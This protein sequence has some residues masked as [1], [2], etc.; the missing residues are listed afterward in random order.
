MTSDARAVACGARDALQNDNVRRAMEPAIS[1]HAA[2]SSMGSEANPEVAERVTLVCMPWASTVRPSLGVGTLVA[3]ARAHGFS[4]DALDPHLMLSSMVGVDAY[5]GFAETRS[6]FGL[7]EHLFAVDIFGREALDSDA[8][9]DSML[10]AAQ[11]ESQASGRNA[12]LQLRDQVVPE[13]LDRCLLEIES[14]GAGIVGFTCTFNQV[15]A[16]IAMA[17]RLK[18]RRPSLRILLGGAC[19]HGSMGEAYARA[20]PFI[21]HVFTGEADDAFPKL[22]GC[23]RDGGDI[24]AIPGVTH[25]G[26][27]ALPATLTHGLDRLPVPDYSSYFE[28]RSAYTG[29][30]HTLGPV[31]ELPF[32]SS[33]GCWWGQKKHCTFCGLNN[34]GMAFRAKSPA[35][36]VSELTQLARTHELLRFTAADNILDYRG[37]DTLLPALAELGVDLQL[38]YE[39]K[40]NLTRDDVAGLVRAGVR[41][42]QPGIESFS[43]GVL[44]LMRKG[45]TGLQNIELIKWLCEHGVAPLYNILVGFPGETDAHY[46]EQLHLIQ[47]IFHLP[48]PSGDAT[49][50]QVHRFAP[51]FNTPD[52]LGIEGLRPASFYEHLIPRE[53]LDA[54]QYAYFFEHT[55]PL[56]AAVHRHLGALNGALRQWREGSPSRTLQ[57]GPG[58]VQVQHPDAKLEVLG[59]ADSAVMMAA[60][61]RTSMKALHGKLDGALPARELDAAV[62]RLLQCGYLVEQGGRVLGVLPFSVPRREAD[63]TRW[64]HRWLGV[65]DDREKR[66]APHR[67][68]TLSA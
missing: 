30:G 54:N 21:D 25:R 47:R 49:Q 41:W 28:N 24:E 48:P 58:Y 26:E 17:R 19:V 22:L 8:Y 40:A 1:S 60:D 12:L 46:E 59:V 57:L 39:I 31:K 11:G 52:A 56:D 35:R 38:F 36:V 23:L 45:T 32:E 66:E 33:R 29:S 6:L 10:G 43:D 20:F 44:R 65:A 27:L 61:R 14:R 51:F 13:F 4:C 15:L 55:T 7:A 68:L 3:L 64:L 18:Q 9:L 37:Y 53:V 67:K 63:L 62:Q 5:E 50:V 2:D 42:V 16:S 34:E